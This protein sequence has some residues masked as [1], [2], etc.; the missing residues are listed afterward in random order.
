MINLDGEFKTL[1]CTPPKAGTTNWNK[2]LL[3]L[4]IY[5]NRGII[6]GQESAYHKLFALS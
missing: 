3:V 5:N 1:I 2:A 6:V 4:D